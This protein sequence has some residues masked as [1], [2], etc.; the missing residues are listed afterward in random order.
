[1]LDIKVRR[2]KTKH[3]S[4]AWEMRGIAGL[5]VWLRNLNQY[6]YYEVEMQYCHSYPEKKGKADRERLKGVLEVNTR[7]TSGQILTIMNLQM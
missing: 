5:Q 6:L 1:M 4:P 3:N 7:L 2:E